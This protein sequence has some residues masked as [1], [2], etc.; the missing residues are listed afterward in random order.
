MKV[1]QAES[2]LLCL[3]G[4]EIP[5]DAPFGVCPECLFGVA[6]EAPRESTRFGE[7]ELLEK[8]DRGGMGVVYKAQ[9]LRS[10]RVEALKMIL[11]GELASDEE[12]YRFNLEARA[13]SSLKHPNIITIYQVG[14]VEGR[15]YFTM[16]WMPKGSLAA[17]IDEYLGDHR[18][19]AEFLETIALAVHY[20]HDH[21]ILHRDLKPANILLDDKGNPYVADFGLAKHLD[22]QGEIKTRSG[23]LAGTP[24]YMAPEQLDGGGQAP[25]RAVDVWSLGV[26]LF[27]MLTGKQP[28]TGKSVGE[29]IEQVVGKPAPNPRS[30]QATVD[31]DLA[32]I[33]LR[34]LDRHP[35]NRYRSAIEFARDLRKYLNGE[36]IVPLSPTQRAWHW[37]KRQPF[38]AALVVEATLLVVIA[39]SAVFSG[40]AAQ[41]KDRREEVLRANE[42][43]ARWVAGTVLFKLNG[44]RDAVA[45]T[46]REF[47]PE[48]IDELKKDDN[49]VS[50]VLEA[51]CDTLR[52]RY[53]T[54]YGDRLAL[55]D[56]FVLDKHGIIRARSAASYKAT[57]FS[58]DVLGRNYDWRD[59]FKGA[60]KLGKAKSHSA[61]ISRA[62]LS[63]PNQ[64]QRYAISAPI[65]DKND[66]PFAVII[67]TT[68][69][70]AALGT[71]DLKDPSDH[72]HIAMVVAPR[73]NDRTT[74]NNPLPEDYVILVHDS[75]P[76]G[77]TAFLKNTRSVR[78]AVDL[79]NATSPNRGLEQL[80]LPEPNAV[81]SDET[82]C[83]P[84]MDGSCEDAAGNTRK[85]RWLAGFAPIGNTG[86]V[87]IVETPRDAA[88]APLQTLVRRLLLWGVLPFML[89]T[90][91]VAMLVGVGRRWGRRTVDKRAS[92][93]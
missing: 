33:C 65:F 76:E 88:A 56:W 34:C 81:T 44:Y 58:Y 47:P 67:T 75:L 66:E 63:E 28:F 46:A 24:E 36:S 55:Q 11:N 6:L 30:I 77:K 18:K 92:V 83:D 74:K 7:Y 4:H 2:K 8:I 57:D 15:H 79:V 20:G 12:I 41:E 32:T 10:Y 49:D 82:F 68:N 86:F 84:V 60:W 21:G 23:I 59:Y 27:Q 22:H 45:K 85:G 91:L 87:A 31:G 16:E 80:L 93:R 43:A 64:T 69:T 51:Y 14:E 9:H 19:I 70:G 78:K 3:A 38:K 62:I 73:D 1:D 72:H 90:A 48:F 5:E 29:I 89:G 50:V 40:A 13:A 26:I 71:L 61:Y 17:H 25:T 42:Y 54:L 52:T 39:T 35:E 37:C 53:A